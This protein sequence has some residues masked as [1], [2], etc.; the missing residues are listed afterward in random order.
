V[1]TEQHRKLIEHA[2]AVVEKTTD[3]KHHGFGILQVTVTPAHRVN[4]WAPELRTIGRDEGAWHT[5]RA[6]IHAT[7]LAGSVFNTRVGWWHPDEGGPCT[8]V[9]VWE[10]PHRGTG[11]MRR[12]HAATVTVG[13]RTRVDAGESYVVERGAGHWTEPGPDGAVTSALMMDMVDTRAAVFVPRRG[14]IPA[15]AFGA[16]EADVVKVRERAAV[17]LRAVLEGTVAR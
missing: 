5:H 4:I 7:V 17:M 15:A 14:G 10:V 1:I 3:W 13:T 16:V 9:D 12:T 2:L 6:R 8:P 11:A